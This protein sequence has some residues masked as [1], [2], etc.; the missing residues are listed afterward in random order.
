MDEELLE[1]IKGKLVNY[2]V[3]EACLPMQVQ[4]KS[5][6]LIDMVIESRK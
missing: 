1:E 4:I 5:L 2:W 3:N 6:A